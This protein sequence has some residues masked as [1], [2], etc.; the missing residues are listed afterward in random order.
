MLNRTYK[1]VCRSCTTYHHL[2]LLDL[3]DTNENVIS[4][5]ENTTILKV[6][7]DIEE[8]LTETKRRCEYCGAINWQVEELKF[9]KIFSHQFIKNDKFFIIKIKRNE[10]GSVNIK[11]DGDTLVAWQFAHAAVDIAEN[12]LHNKHW[13]KF[14]QHPELMHNPLVEIVVSCK[15]N[16][17]AENPTLTNLKIEKFSYIGLSAQEFDIVFNN[18]RTKILRSPWVEVKWQD[19]V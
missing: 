8:A 2:T 13:S 16:I 15:S 4:Y 17:Y 9:D 18:I 11:T 10:D 6:S 3:I 14:I 1:I 12:Y 7:D 5:I 19:Y